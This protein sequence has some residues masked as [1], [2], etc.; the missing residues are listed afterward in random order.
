MERTSSQPSDKKQIDQKQQHSQPQEAPPTPVKQVTPIHNAEE[1]GK[2]SLPLGVFL[3]GIICSGAFTNT[4][5]GTWAVHG[6]QPCFV[7]C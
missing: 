4:Q 7:A 1:T 2:L 6:L 3:V 5:V